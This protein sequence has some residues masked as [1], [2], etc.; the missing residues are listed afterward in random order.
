[1]VD[2]R[3]KQT[4]VFISE[5]LKERALDE[6]VVC[7]IRRKSLTFYPIELGGRKRS[8]K[9]KD[10]VGGLLFCMEDI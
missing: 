1:M 3:D 9:R 8:G 6:K 7:I 2:I 4:R 10:H 5:V